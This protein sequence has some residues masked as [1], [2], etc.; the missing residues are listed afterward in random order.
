MTHIGH[1]IEHI[2][3]HY[4]ATYPDQDITAAVIDR[5]H[6]DRNWA[7]IGY[8]WFIRRD[9][10]LEQG[11]PEN[12]QGAHVGGQ[13]S[14]KIGICYAGGLD[15]KTGPNAGVWNPTLEQEETM[16]SVV[17]RLKLRWPEAKVVGHRDLAA[18]QCPGGDAAAWW[19]RMEARPNYAPQTPSN[20]F[21]AFFAAILRLFRRDR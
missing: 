19:A 8:H 4:S 13:N 17:R 9:G 18:T 1:P 2:V 11:R 16:A 3:I 20:P 7:G 12:R 10:T 6:K 5:W 14:R 15:R 21:A